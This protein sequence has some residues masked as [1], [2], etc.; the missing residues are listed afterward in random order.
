MMLSM[1]AF[2]WLVGLLLVFASGCNV[3]THDVQF[4]F[5]FI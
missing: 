3:L 2:G 1:E 5:L 4:L